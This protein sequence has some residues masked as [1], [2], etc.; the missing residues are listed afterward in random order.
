MQPTGPAERDPDGTVDR[1]AATVPHR[2]Q[3]TPSRG[4]GG[5]AQP[6][7]EPRDAHPEQRADDRVWHPVAG[8]LV[9]DEAGHAHFVASLTHRTTDRLRPPMSATCQAA[10]CSGSA[11]CVV[12][13][14]GNALLGS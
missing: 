10:T 4:P 6:L 3:T 11:G 7:V 5:A 8:P 1:V 12:V 13:V 9:G 14:C 2:V